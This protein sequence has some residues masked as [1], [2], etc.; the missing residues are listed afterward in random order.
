MASGS[1]RIVAAQMAFSKAARRLEKLAQSRSSKKVNYLDGL[2]DVRRALDR[3]ADNKGK[4]ALGGA[5]G[6]IA[7]EYFVIGQ[8]TR[9]VVSNSGMISYV[10]VTPS[11]E[12]HG[13]VLG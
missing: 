10:A 8:G 3:T 6:G 13:S 7:D 11:S 2:F 9:Y 1:Y 5:G 4:K 12:I